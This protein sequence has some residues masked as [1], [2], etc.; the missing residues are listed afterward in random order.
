MNKKEVSAFLESSERSV[1]NYVKRGLLSVRYEKGRTRDVPVFDDEE[2]RR[3]KAQ[4]DARRAL[5]PT[6]VKEDTEST[7]REYRNS[8]SLAP[9]SLLAPAPLAEYLSRIATALEGS[10]APELLTPEEVCERLKVGKTTLRG[11]VREGKLK[12]VNVGRLV[13]FRPADLRAFIENL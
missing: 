9:Q 12:A 3:L 4:L 8:E 13:R 1:E 11:L 7:E 6:I 10:V 5:V 2:V